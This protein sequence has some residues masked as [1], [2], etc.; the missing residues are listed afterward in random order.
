MQSVNCLNG[1]PHRC[2]YCYAR[3][4]AMRY[5][6]L[7]NP[8]DWGQPGRY[9]SIRQKEVSK[10]RRRVDGTVMFP[11]THD[12]T[13]EFLEPCLRVMQ[14]ILEAGNRL[15]I[16]TKP[17]LPCIELIGRRFFAPE[18]KDRI[19]FRFT[20]SAFDDSILCYWEPGAPCYFERVDCLKLAWKMGYR[21]SISIEPMLDAPKVV[22][23]F[24]ILCPW[25]TDTIWLGKMN[26]ID[27]RVIPGTNPA[28]IQRIKDGQTDERIREIY[29]QLK[30]EPKV[31]WKE[32]I[33]KV[34][35]L[36]AAQVAGMD[37]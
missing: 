34:V 3:A 20:I 14:N 32:S 21:T 26:Q 25:V 16:V 22:K 19:V 35:G 15:L 5:G 9:L 2:R 8:E 17:H 1:C 28:E 12:V 29:A 36:P 11:T 6:R 33:K 10:K 24:Q 13:P 4:D 31:R 30:D 7:K 37:V 18:F 23:L 27:Q